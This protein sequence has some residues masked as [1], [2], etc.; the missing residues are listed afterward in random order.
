MSQLSA[1]FRQSPNETKRYILDFTL[2]LDPGETV[3]STVIA[4]TSPTNAPATPALTCTNVLVSPNGLQIVFYISGGV[5]GNSYEV[6][7]LTKTSL[8][9]V[10]EDVVQYNIA[11]KV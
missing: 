6:Q 3:L 2:D 11:V 10:L 7:F 9:K 4:I 5:D 1:S 8:S